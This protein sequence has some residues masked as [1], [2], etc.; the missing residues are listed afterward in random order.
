MASKE[1]FTLVGSRDGGLFS[2]MLL[3]DHSP[4]YH[5]HFRFPIEAATKMV[6]VW[7]M[8]TEKLRRRRGQPKPYNRPQLQILGA[9]S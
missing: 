9:E 7:A 5:E 2:V 3:R 6:E 8:L 1:G 4:V